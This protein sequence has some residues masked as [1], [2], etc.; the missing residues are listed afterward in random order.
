MAYS[1]EHFRQLAAEKIEFKR[2]QHTIGVEVL[3]RE[4]AKKYGINVEAAA[5]AALTHDLAKDFPPQ[6]QLEK[7]R[8]WKLIYYPEDLQIPQ[9]L[10]GRLAAYILKKEYELDNQDILKAVANHTL[11][12]PGMSSLEMLI[13]ST[14]L[15][16]PGRDFPG[17]DKLREKLYHDLREGTLA[18]VEHILNYL[19]TINKPVHPLTILTY[20]DL[21]KNIKK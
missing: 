6:E 13:Y 14:D 9:V 18:C 10:H 4:L 21:K 5:L 1:L 3:A 15:T 12:R 16:E 20:E 11:G 17:V 19:Q 2:F 7:A 8:K